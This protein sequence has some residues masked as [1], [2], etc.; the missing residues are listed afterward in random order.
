MRETLAVSVFQ[1]QFAKC[2]WRA[3]AFSLEQR[4]LR[5]WQGTAPSFDPHP[6]CGS[7]AID[8]CSS[9]SETKSL[10]SCV[11]SDTFF[12]NSLWLYIQFKHSH[13]WPS[14]ISRPHVHRISYFIDLYLM[15]FKDE[16]QMFSVPRLR[17]QDDMCEIQIRKIS[18]ENR[19]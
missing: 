8:I 12:Y 4:R 15:L 14:V 18:R 6:I 2:G 1:F 10:W 7:H 9:L 11:H 17:W 16:F 3:Y 5:A 13:S 19:L